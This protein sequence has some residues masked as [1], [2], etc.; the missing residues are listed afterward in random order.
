MDEGVGQA[1]GDVLGNAVG[2]A[3]SPLPLVA[4]IM[5]LMSASG[6][7]RAAA[8]VAGWL[9]G[10]ALVLGVFTTMGPLLASDDPRVVVSALKLAVGALLLA[11][12][13]RTWR[14]SGSDGEPEQPRWMGRVQEATVPSCAG[15]GLALSAANPKNL[16]LTAAAGGSIGGADLSVAAGLVVALAYVVLAS[17]VMLAVV[18]AAAISPTRAE[19]V[20][21][22]MREWLVLHNGA[23]LV[24]VMLVMGANLLGAGIRGLA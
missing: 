10:L 20:L 6:R 14:S 23:V 8:M 7:A 12:A 5:L 16:G 15:V 1:F 17:S 11:L 13:V 2:V 4:V 19:P 24:V 9:V 3:L 18:G 21:E 22:R